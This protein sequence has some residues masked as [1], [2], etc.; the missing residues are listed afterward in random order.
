MFNYLKFCKDFKNRN[1]TMNFKI[2]KKE[3]DVK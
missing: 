3:K 2:Q 1:I